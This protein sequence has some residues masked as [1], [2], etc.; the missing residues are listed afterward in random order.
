MFVFV[1]LRA[2]LRE[3]WHK[4]RTKTNQLPFYYKPSFVKSS[5]DKMARRLFSSLLLA[6]RVFARRLGVFSVLWWFHCSAPLEFRCLSKKKV[7]GNY[8]WMFKAKVKEKQHSCVA[9]L[10][11]L[12]KY[13][14]P[15]HTHKKSKRVTQSLSFHLK[16]QMISRFAKDHGIKCYTCVVIVGGAVVWW[17]V[18]STPERAVR[19]RAL[20]GRC[21]LGV[22]FLAL[23]SWARNFTL[24]VHLSTQVFKWVPANLMLGVTL[25]W[26]SIP[27][28]GE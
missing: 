26:T 17:L 12:L 28:R 27:S 15:R 6:W 24:T 10:L 22:V 7:P 5:P 21:V 1:K 3:I 14:T 8:F 23:C 9:S 13:L 25:R 11:L 16:W 20:A 18:R 19:V 2:N 4:Y